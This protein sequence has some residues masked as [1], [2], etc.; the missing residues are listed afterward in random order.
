MCCACFQSDQQHDEIREIADDVI[1]EE[2]VIR[3]VK[4]P[5]HECT[6]ISLVT[7]SVFAGCST[8]GVPFCSTSI[9]TAFCAASMFLTAL[10]FVSRFARRPA[11]S[12]AVR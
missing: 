7:V 4:K 10:I 11:F 2:R 12:S 1:P 6:A 8:V 9:S 5:D 3:G